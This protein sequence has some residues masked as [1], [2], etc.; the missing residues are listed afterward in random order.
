MIKNRNAF[1]RHVK[2][3]RSGLCSNRL[4]LF[5]NPV[6]AGAD[7]HSQHRFFQSGYTRSPDFQ[8]SF[9]SLLKIIDHHNDLL[10]MRKS[11]ITQSLVVVPQK[12]QG[13]CAEYFILF[14]NSDH[15]FIKKKKFF[16]FSAP[17]IC[18]S[19][20]RICKSAHSR[21]VPVV[22]RR[23]PGP[24]HLYGDRFA[25]NGVVHISLRLFRTHIGYPPHCTVCSR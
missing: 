19:V 11:S 12:F 20:V 10:C 18:P 14:V 4:F 21:L 8:Q 9:S 23:G 7:Q 25:H 22:N 13:A 16:I 1:R 6:S 17:W 24:C 3:N 5:R 15:F 2:T